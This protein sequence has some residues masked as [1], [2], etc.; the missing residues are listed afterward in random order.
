MLVV[1]T[2]ASPDPRSGGEIRTL[3]LLQALCQI[4]DVT[5]AV[6]AVP[7]DPDRLR[8]V[9][10]ACEVVVRATPNS[11][12]Q[13]RL[14]A[15]RRCW[16]LTS[17]RW[18]RPEVAALVSTFEAR[19][20]LVV[21]EHIYLDVYRPREAAYVLS[22][23]NVEAQ[24]HRSLPRP[25]GMIARLERVWELAMLTRLER[26]AAARARARFVT[27]SRDD[28]IGLGRSDALVVEN[29]TD[30]VVNADRRPRD[31]GLTFIGS[32]TWHP[33]RAAVQWWCEQ[34]VPHLP[35][36]L[37]AL[38]VVGRGGQEA[39]AGYGRLDVRGEV[40]DIG[41]I[42]RRSRVVVVPLQHGG[43][44]R[45]K[46]LE[47]MAWRRPV[48]STTKGAEGLRVKPSEHLLIAD[49]GPAFAQAVVKAWDDNALA[50]ALVDMAAALADSYDWGP[51][52]A[53]YAA[54]VLRW[55]Q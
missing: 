47:A 45:L 15:V 54:A 46:I 5:V 26:R 38:T 27:V 25:R 17:A 49:E 40:A 23:Q 28:S 9:S 11:P 29:G 16:P 4:A 43:G 7:T 21:L 32:M 31:G 35:D 24:V 44:T 3:R 13:A 30:P 22:T 14:L 42:L 1:T 10:G 52:G 50:D 34:V 48:V 19:G 51:I 12:V 37:P 39:F 53:R 55:A 2:E 6:V 41:D 20:D 18:W 8:D 36:R 33:N